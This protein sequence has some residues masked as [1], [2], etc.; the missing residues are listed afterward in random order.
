[1][2]NFIVVLLTTLLCV[3]CDQK[4]EY[5]TVIPKDA[6]LVAS[7]NLMTLG[8]KASL[9]DYKGLIDMGLMQVQREDAALYEQLKEIVNDPSSL[10]LALNEPVYIFALE[11]G[12]SGAAVMKVTDADKLKQLAKQMLPQQSIEYTE[13]GN[14]LW[15]AA[16]MPIVVTDQLLLAGT[17]RLTLEK[18]LERQADES[19]VSTELWD[20]LSSTKGDIKMAVIPGKMAQVEEMVNRQKMAA[21]Y[22]AMGIDIAENSTVAGLDFLPGKVVLTSKTHNAPEAEKWQEE[23]MG[24]VDGSFMDKMPADPYIWLGLNMNGE[25]LAA[26]IDRFVEAI[27]TVNNANT[28]QVRELLASIN[29]EISFGMNGPQIG[30]RSLLPDLTLFAK[31]KNSRLEEMLST[32]GDVPGLS[33]GMVGDDIFYLTTNSEVAATPGKELGKSAV[34]AP[35]AN[36]VEGTYGYATING[37]TLLQYL[38]E[39]SLRPQEREQVEMVLNVCERIEAKAQSVTEGEVT[40]YL[41]NKEKNALE[42]LIQLAV[43]MN[44]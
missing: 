15:V 6:P 17:D 20:E 44:M 26:L 1:M 43:T 19:F 33:H 41:V 7:V 31:V 10:G 37:K 38:P 24:E 32:L 29:G 12:E 30:S 9:K 25:S 34:D 16:P 36:E 40:L 39:A 27:P 42:Q 5:A 28:M 4:S 3:A 13:E 23:L 8:E 18:L 14:R 35:W 21:I 2:K 22:D 11:G